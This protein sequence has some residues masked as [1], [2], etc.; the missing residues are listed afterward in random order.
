VNEANATLDH[1]DAC[2]VNVS[3][4]WKAFM[5]LELVHSPDISVLYPSTTLVSLSVISEARFHMV[6]EPL[7]WN[8]A[9][10]L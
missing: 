4:L 9:G 6:A 1:D 2:V 3:A 7:Q 10:C 8:P 5:I